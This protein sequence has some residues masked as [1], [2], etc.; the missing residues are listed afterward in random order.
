MKN[1]QDCLLCRLIDDFNKLKTELRK[2]VIYLVSKIMQQN[3]CFFYV[4]WFY[5][6]C[7]L[8]PNISIPPSTYMHIYNLET[9]EKLFQMN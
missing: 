2:I 1:G 6:H 5:L 8:I 4:F 9:C 7:A 3:V